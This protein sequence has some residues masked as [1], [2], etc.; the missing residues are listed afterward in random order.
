MRITLLLSLLLV[1]LSVS[2]KDVKFGKVSKEDVSATRHIDYPEANAAILHKSEWI[3][4]DYQ[5]DIGWTVTREVH[6]RIKIYKKDGF[7]WATLQIPLYA[8]RGGEETIS[9]IKGFTFNIEGGKLVSK[10]LKNDGVFEEKVNKYRNKTS[11]TMPEVKEGSILDI[12]YKIKSPMFWN[13]DEFKFQYDI[14]L[15]HAEVRL[16]VPEYFIFKKHSKG[17][18]T[19]QFAE[20]KKN[21][22]MNIAYR[23]S[24]NMGLVGRSTHNN[25]TLSFMENIY[26]M[27]VSN[28]PAMLEEKYT[29][30]IDNYKTSVKFELASTHFP[31]QPYENYSLTWEGVAKSIYSYDDFGAELNKK[32]YFKDDL[33]PL[34]NGL[35]SNIEKAMTI[36]QFVKTKMNW[37]NYYG[38]TCSDQGIRKAYKEGK[39]NVAEI[40]LMLTAMFRYAG[41]DAHPVLVSTRSHGIPLFPTSDGFNYVIT[42]LQLENGLVLFDATEKNTVPNIL[43]MRALNWFGRLIREDGSS[44]QVDLMPKTKSVDAIMMSVVLND[45]G[46]IEGEYQEQ[47]S[48]NSA[49]LFR[50]N[51]VAGTEEKYLD[52]LEKKYGDIEI[53]NFNLQNQGNLSKPV[54]QAFNFVKEDAFDEISGKLYISPLFYLTTTVNPFKTEKREFP[55]DFGYPW[56]DQY[57]INIAIPDGYAVESVPESIAVGLPDNLGRFKYFV[58][59][60]NN[61]INVRVDIELNTSLISSNYYAQ[62]KEFYNQIIKKE[63]EKVVLVKT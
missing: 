48:A 8:G 14:P 49:L 52:D 39:G 55:V 19:I 17:F 59:A 18:Q 42:G 15:D 12:E 40:N 37:D 36:F 58:S 50:N 34:L 1:H 57:M 63:L 22:S 30:N 4:Y 28:I 35:S 51:F 24:D 31:N 10:K 38:V 2:A 43:P 5:Y 20:S 29:N 62:L 33:D 32:G 47:Y 16:D 61:K 23:S 46:S 60:A 26:T 25:G 44:K 45:D 13:I 9:G 7:D 27:E 56:K 21:R 53:S 3:W 54:V 6:F 41:L 11:I